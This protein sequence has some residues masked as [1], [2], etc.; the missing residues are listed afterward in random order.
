MFSLRV[1]RVYDPSGPEDGTRFLVDRLWPRGL[2]KE[3][4][5]IDQWLKEAA[6]S[7]ELRRWFGHDPHRWTEFQ[8]RYFSELARQSESLQMIREKAQKGTVTL[9]YGARDR[10]HNNA[11][12]LKQYLEKRGSGSAHT[13][14]DMTR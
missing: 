9:L 11:V 12:A 8:R 4:A 6:P 5:M 10:D 3:K 14:R 7:E 1:K 2:T 13:K